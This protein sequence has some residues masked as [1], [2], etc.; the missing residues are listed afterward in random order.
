MA[1]D[2]GLPNAYP[3]AL[4]SAVIPCAFIVSYSLVF[5]VPWPIPVRKMGRKIAAP[6]QTFLTLQEAKAILAGSSA[7]AQAEDASSPFNAAPLWITVVLASLAMMESVAWLAVSCYQFVLVASGSAALWK[8]VFPLLHALS[9]LYAAVMPVVRPIATSPWDL[10]C[11]L[12]CFLIMALVRVGTSLFWAGASSIPLPGNW[13][14][15]AW[16]VDV[17]APF[18]GLVII[19]GMPVG[20]PDSEEEKVQIVSRCASSETSVT[21]CAQ[22]EKL[23]PEDYTSLWAWVTFNWV[24]PLIG[25]VSWLGRMT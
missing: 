12:L 21:P 19:L 20:L 16:T 1:L 14:L 5:Y 8:A 6:F 11:L 22:G 24:A 4:L 23:T 10:L 2:T 18:L 13:E 9:W 17:I 7:T 15:V 25:K 3:L